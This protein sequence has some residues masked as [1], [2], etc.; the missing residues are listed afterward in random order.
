MKKQLKWVS[1]V[2]ATLLFGNISGQV[3]NPQPRILS[4]SGFE[5]G[6]SVTTIDFD[7]DGDLDLVIQNHSNVYVKENLG[8]YNFQLHNLGAVGNF[9]SSRAYVCMPVDIDNDGDIDVISGGQQLEV[10]RNDGAWNFSKLQIAP[11]NN[12]RDFD[13]EDIDGDGFMDIICGATKSNLGSLIVYFNRSSFGSIAFDELVVAN[14]F[15][16]ETITALA[17]DMN[18]DNLPDLI[19]G[20]ARQPYKLDMFIQ[21]ETGNFLRQP[22]S[23]TIGGIRTIEAADLEKDGDI[24]LLVG[25][26]VNNSIKVLRNVG[27]NQFNEITLRSNIND[28]Q[29]IQAA[30]INLDGKL[31]VI[32]SDYDGNVVWEEYTIENGE[33]IF[34]PNNLTPFPNNTWGETTDFD[35]DGD[36]DYI[37]ID[38]IS[39][40]HNILLYENTL[41]DCLVEEKIINGIP[42]TYVGFPSVFN[43][44]NSD[45]STLYTVVRPATGEIV[46]SEMGNG[47]TLTI[48]TDTLVYGSNVFEVY[49]QK[50][51]TCEP[52]FLFTGSL[53]AWDTP[54]EKNIFDPNEIVVAQNPEISIPESVFPVDMN[55]DGMMD[56]LS[57]T[58]GDHKV[59]LHVN[60]GKFEFDNVV[61]S[62]QFQGGEDVKAIDMDLDGDM[63]I[64]AAF[65]TSDDLVWFENDGQLNFTPHV[66]DGNIDH[67]IHFYA[68]DIDGDNDIDLV[69]SPFTSGNLNLYT[70]DGNQNFSKRVIA[71]GF[72]KSEMVVVRDINGDGK[73]DILYGNAYQGVNSKLVWLKQTTTMEFEQILISTNIQSLKGLAIEDIDND[74]DLDFFTA[75]TEDDK[76][77]LFRNTGNELFVE[78]TLISNADGAEHVFTSDMDLDGDQDIVWVSF[79]DNK[80]YWQENIDGGYNFRPYEISI[81]NAGLVWSEPADFDGDSDLDIVV[82][83]PHGDKI[84]IF[85][86][87]LFDCQIEDVNVF[88]PEQAYFRT[89]AEVIIPLPQEGVTYYLEDESGEISVEGY[90]NTQHENE[91]V[92]NTPEL[93]LGTN[94]FFI[95]AV[96]ANCEDYL[97]TPVII[98]GIETPI[99]FFF[100]DN[101]AA[102]SEDFIVPVLI[103]PH[104]S[105]S[106]INGKFSY[107]VSAFSNVYLD[108][109][110]APEGHYCESNTDTING[111][112]NFVWQG[113]DFVAGHGAEDTAVAFNFVFVPRDTVGIFDINLIDHAYHWTV[114]HVEGYAIPFT[115]YN[116]TV[117]LARF[118]TLQSE[119]RTINGEMVPDVH[120]AF[121]GR[122]G[123]DTT[124]VD[125]AYYRNERL[126][127]GDFTFNIAKDADNDPTNG[128][129]VV[130]ITLLRRHMLQIS[131]LSGAQLVAADVNN[132]GNQNLSDVLSTKLIIL[133]ILNSFGGEAW[134]F[135][136]WNHNLEDPN[137]LGFEFTTYLQEDAL[138]DFM[139]I[140]LGDIDGSW[141]GPLNSS[142]A[143]IAFDLI[144]GEKNAEGHIPVYLPY[145]MNLTGIQFTLETTKGEINIINGAMNIQQGNTTEGVAT[146]LWE[147]ASAQG[148]VFSENEPIFYIMT[149]GEVNFSD[150]FTPCLVATD[151]LEVSR[152]G[153]AAT[154]SIN[155]NNGLNQCLDV[156]PVPATNHINVNLC[157]DVTVTGYQII[158]TDGKVIS[159]K[160]VDSN[161]ITIENA[162]LPAPG[163]YQLIIET[164]NGK[165]VKPI[166][167][168]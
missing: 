67:A 54:A 114:S 35:L 39:G 33:M 92:F 101:Y 160:Q 127:P 91:V 25:T 45:V 133:E 167:I 50:S 123:F 145:S 121:N 134:R 76:I 122:G 70:N 4:D 78:E 93:E 59:I 107:D 118:F 5:I 146:G 117:E 125:L 104:D 17:H 110:N 44:E 166:V 60:L 105:I 53:N 61:I 137:A 168:K 41:N 66:I 102:N 22:I 14:D 79:L 24:D 165:A 94:E 65:S 13:I 2:V 148:Q 96:H 16:T 48:Y 151:A 88:T 42:N 159:A 85:K 18:G 55:N 154:T 10:F 136:P 34:T 140:K 157:N 62:N 1:A 124:F 36:M 73:K 7:G 72:G 28:P 89:S 143:P 142:K 38:W 99:S 111:T 57:T 20:S 103:N 162:D 11:I 9:S 43:I 23:T 27:G 139:A 116:G 40:R 77:A 81:A 68:S 113:A 56:F 164:T 19:C 156:F 32:W 87:I 29:G 109:A 158:T 97:Q 90:I 95:Y 108:T 119:F 46:G 3:F 106:G 8:N 49:G 69:A 52:I 6:E 128:I 115:L 26:W 12:V 112:V 141:D 144:L 149:E 80:I 100:Q 153:G 132:D 83:S 138:L 31:D 131:E 129:N 21:D 15:T 51:E 63:D 126:L 64:V 130:D 135:A 75:S 120:F 74:G 71:S 152:F 161:S 86:N 163:V 58:R 150:R 82:A 30:D 155:E 98:E 47:N 37:A 147:D 84:S